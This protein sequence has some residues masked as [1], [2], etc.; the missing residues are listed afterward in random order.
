MTSHYKAKRK[1]RKNNKFVY[2]QHLHRMKTALIIITIINH[3][4]SLDL[5]LRFWT[6]GPR[7]PYSRLKSIPSTENGSD[8]N[9]TP[10]NVNQIIFDIFSLVLYTFLANSIVCCKY[11]YISV[12]R[13]ISYQNETQQWEYPNC[14]TVFTKMKRKIT[15][16][17]FRCL[18]QSH[19]QFTFD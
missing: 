4:H 7:W 6:G 12:A 11:I 19:T 8:A 16:S 15:P 5:P 10:N 1:R 17:L 18:I 2:V 3:N 13:W 14:K 9:K